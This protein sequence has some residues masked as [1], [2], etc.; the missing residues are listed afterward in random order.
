MC[1]GQGK[2]IT[3]LTVGGVLVFLMG[4]KPGAQ[5]WTYAACALFSVRWIVRNSLFCVFSVPWVDHS[6][7]RYVNV[8]AC[9]FPSFLICLENVKKKKKSKTEI[10]ASVQE[11]K[12]NHTRS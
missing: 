1:S 8:F 6:N 7:A 2:S 9:F 3:F 11:N 4:F 10:T 12:S 5:F